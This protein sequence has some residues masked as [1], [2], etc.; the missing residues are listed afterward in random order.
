MFRETGLGNK[1]EEVAPEEN[2][3]Q[4]AMS[5]ALQKMVQDE[6]NYRNNLAQELKSAPKSERKEILEKAKEDPKYWKTRNE[7]IKNNEEEKTIDDGLGVLIKRKNLYHGNTAEY[8]E[9]FDRAERTTVGEG[10]YLTS[11]AED[12]AGYSFKR[13]ESRGGN[14]IIY[15][16]AVQLYRKP[17]TD[18]FIAIR[19]GKIKSGNI[20]EAVGPAL[21]KYF[22]EFVESLGYDGLI[23]IEGGEGDV[24]NHDSYVVFNPEKVRIGQRHNL[25]NEKAVPAKEKTPEEILEEQRQKEEAAEKRKLRMDALQESTKKRARQIESGEIEQGELK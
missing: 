6:E 13:S 3:E 15:E 25:K 12:A 11:K 16:A 7:K 2:A 22:S 9:N 23:A 18:A 17:F 24:G 4:S 5:E 10:V 1:P 8:G 14:P 19:S 20:S 21:G